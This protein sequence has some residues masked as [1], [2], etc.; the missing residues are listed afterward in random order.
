MSIGTVYTVM[1]IPPEE[2]VTTYVVAG[3]ITVGVEI[4]AVDNALVGEHF[5][6]STPEQLAEIAANKPDNLD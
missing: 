2:D 1:P 6:D 3:A 4:R 5:K